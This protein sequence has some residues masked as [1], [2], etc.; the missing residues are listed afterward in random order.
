MSGRKQHYIPQSLLK[1]FETPSKGKTKKVWVF[2]KGQK[3]FLSATE[4]VAAQRDFYS[5]PLKDGL[6]TLD[7][8][9][10]GYEIELN[11]LIE[12]LLKAPAD[13]PVD[14]TVAAE[15]VT[16]LTIRAAFLRGVATFGVNH[17]IGSAVDLLGSEEYLR[18][19][20]GIDTNTLV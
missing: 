1:S 11:R 8:R 14:S 7:D 15:V 10:T 12:T 9:I 3:P 16:H 13:L 2:K 17:L 20:W 4:D 5:D 6:L 19:S 18:A